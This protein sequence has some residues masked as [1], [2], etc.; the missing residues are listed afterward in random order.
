ME[1]DENWPLARRREMVLWAARLL[2][3]RSTRR[4][5]REHLRV[6]TGR[7]PLIVENFD[8]LRVGQDASLGATTRVG[9]AAKRA[10]WLSITVLADDP[11]TVDEDIVRQIIQFQKP[12]HMAYRFEIRKAGP[13][14]VEA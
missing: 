2:R 8:G 11:S 14:E 10:N 5:L 1:L 3:W 7:T 6:Y 4:G 12:A 9:G 13:D